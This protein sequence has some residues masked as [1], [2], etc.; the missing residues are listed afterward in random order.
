MAEETTKGLVIKRLIQVGYSNTQ[1]TKV[2]GVIWYKED[3]YKDYD[4]NIV[5]MFKSASKSLSGGSDGRPDFTVTADNQNIIIVIEC[6]DNV[7]NHQ[8]YDNLDQ[9]KSGIG[10]KEE[11][12]KYA[13]NGALH[14]AQYVN[15]DNDVIAIAVSGTK[16][17]NMRITSFVLPK[18]GGLSDIEL[19]ED[20]DYSNTIMY[21]DDYKKNADIKLRRNQEESDRVFSELSTYAIACANYLRSNGISAKDRAGFI[22]A[23]VLALTNEDS[24]LYRSTKIAYDNMLTSKS[25]TLK[26]AIGES[27]IQYLKASLKDIWENKDN[28]PKMKS[29]SLKEYYNKL[30]TKSLLNSAEGTD[31]KYFKYGDNVLTCCIYSIYENIITVLKNHTDLDIMGTFYTVFLK[32]AKGDAKD[33]GIVLTPKHITELFCDLAEHYMGQ[34]LDD[35]TRVLDICCGTGGFLIASLNRMDMNINNMTISENEKRNKRDIVRKRCL[36]GAESEPEMFALAYANMRF[37]GDGKSNLY[38][39]SSLLKDGKEKGIA[40]KDPIT[41]KKLSLIEELKHERL[42][43]EEKDEYNIVER[44]IDVGMIN[45]PYSLSSNKNKKLKD[46]KQSGQTELDFVYSMLTYLKKGGIGI[47]IVPVSCASNKGKKMRQIIL[48]EHTLL[49]CMSMPKTLFQNSNVGTTTCIMVFKA[50]IPHNDSDKVVFLSRWLEDGFV[51]IPHQGRYDKNNKWFAIKQEWMRQLK[52]LAKDNNAIFMKKEVEITDECLAEAF[53]ETDWTKLTNKN[54]E[55]QLKKYS[56]FKHCFDNDLIFDDKEMLFYLLDN[57]EEFEKQYRP[58][59]CE[60]KVEL[61]IENWKMVNIEKYFK[62]IKGVFYPVDTYGEG[63]MPLVT[64]SD[65]NNGIMKYTNL[66]KAFN[67]NCITIGK[68][69]MSAFY[70]ENDFCCSHDVTVLLS[71]YD[72]F[73]KYIAMFFVGIMS[74]EKF[75]WDYGRQIQL[76]ACKTINIKIPVLYD[77]TSNEA[78][79]DSNGDYIPDYDFME[80]YIKSLL[81]SKNI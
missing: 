75:R 70:Q 23:I 43:D 32:Y 50:H 11:I 10:S 76:N 5:N 67:G 31:K 77:K 51:T 71:K 54:F 52:G 8:A 73:N 47:A 63:D 74:M 56:L 53:V 12:K 6:K 72:K 55:E 78:L 42:Y 68:V 40:G 3:S 41:G 65:T 15:E 49:A 1:D 33:K 4:L 24:S 22:S 48:K 60:E 36:L 25:K 19:I 39:C 45:P 37:H 66:N 7:N 38:S 13:I 14:Y 62:L 27:A 21:V 18:G 46:E 59:F 80:R 79:L 35:S 57:L 61:N 58:S 30:L 34:K 2:N 20:G 29:D 9:Y 64:A 44:V 17:S 81:Y 28:I 69:G 26:D 16:E